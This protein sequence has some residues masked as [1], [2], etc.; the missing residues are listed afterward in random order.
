[1]SKI[2]KMKAIHNDIGLI[3]GGLIDVVTMSK[4][5]KMKA[6][7]NQRARPFGGVAML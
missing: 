3:H 2:G 5:G 7:H 4:I 6:I 1:M